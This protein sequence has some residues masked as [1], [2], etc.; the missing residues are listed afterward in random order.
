MTMPDPQEIYAA[1]LA[2]SARKTAEAM[3]DREMSERTFEAPTAKC[4]DRVPTPYWHNGVRYASHTE[5]A[6]ALGISRAAI[7][8]RVKTMRA[9]A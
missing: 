2:A 9:K 3:H 7:S 8:K 1:A 5:A 4:L 6:K